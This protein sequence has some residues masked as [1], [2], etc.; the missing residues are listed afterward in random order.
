MAEQVERHALALRDPME[1]PHERVHPIERHGDVLPY[2]GTDA[3]VQHAP[4]LAPERPQPVR[5]LEDDGFRM[6]PRL[7]EGGV[8]PTT[9]GADL[10]PVGGLDL[11]EQE[12]GFRPPGGAP[13]D[14]QALGGERVEELDRGQA[15]TRRASEGP[16]ERTQGRLF[17]QGYDPAEPELRLR[18]HPEDDLGGDPERALTPDEQMQQL[19]AD[20]PLL[21]AAPEPNPFPRTE[22]RLHLPHPAPSRTVGERARS[23]GVRTDVPADRAAIR[24]T[25]VRWVEQ[26]ERPESRLED[27][28][29][30]PRTDPDRAAIDGDVRDRVP[31]GQVDH[32]PAS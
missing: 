23:G 10:H 28:V 25:R 31:G 2:P 30:H 13:A 20:R 32:N 8:H 5:V 6:D 16:G 18:S 1:R 11:E 29:H 3:F 26:T 24:R 17:G 22:D 7:P 21:R 4:V 27:A 14:A 15:S 19:R 9:P 12:G